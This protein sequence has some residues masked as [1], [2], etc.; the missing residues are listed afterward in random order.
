MDNEIVNI[1]ATRT[2]LSSRASALVKIANSDLTNLSTKADLHP[3]EIRLLGWQ[4]PPPW[5]R[6][7]D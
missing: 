3:V 2:L 1:S 4:K 7:M 6:S 5:P